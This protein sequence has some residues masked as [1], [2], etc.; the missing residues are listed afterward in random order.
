MFN[1]L[2]VIVAIAAAAFSGC[3]QMSNPTATQPDSVT[4]APST[5]PDVELVPE[6]PQETQVLC[7]AEHTKFVVGKVA[8]TELLEKLGTQTG[9]R[10]VRIL[11]P[12]QAVTLEFNPYRLNVFVDNNYVIEQVTCN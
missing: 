5:P 9:A 12:N 6:T 8:S 2:I 3:A 1:K 7:D 11:T 10:F 4:P